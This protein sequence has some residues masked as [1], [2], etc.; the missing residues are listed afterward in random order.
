[1]Q[2]HRTRWIAGL[3]FALTLAL[4]IP[5]IAILAATHVVDYDLNPAINLTQSGARNNSGSSISYYAVGDTGFTPANL[6][7]GT[8]ATFSITL[9]SDQYAGTWSTSGGIYEVGFTY[10]P[11]T[12]TTDYLTRDG[13]AFQD[14]TN[15]LGYC[16]D[17]Y[18]YVSTSGFGAA[19][20]GYI[21]DN[22]GHTAA[23]YGSKTRFT[24]SIDA[25][26]AFQMTVEHL[27]TD[28]TTV[29]KTE[30]SSDTL[31]G[32]DAS[33][34]LYPY[35]KGRIGSDTLDAWS[36]A[37]SGA[38]LQF[39]QIEEI[40]ETPEATPESTPETT[41]ST[42]EVTPSTPEATPSTP[43]STPTTPE[44]TPSTPVPTVE[45]A[46]PVPPP[47]LRC[48]EHNAD[49]S[50][51]VHAGGASADVS[52]EVFCRVITANGQYQS[53]NGAALT[54]AG[55]IGDQGVIDMGIVQAVDVFSPS[56]S[57]FDNGIVICLKGESDTLL[58][59][60]GSQSPRTAQVIGAYSV[61]DFPGYTCATLFEPGI[62]VLTGSATGTTNSTTENYN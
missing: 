10:S 8:S 7:T 6:D 34:P 49:D 19:Q 29:L 37:Y 39:S 35:V 58:Y 17:D 46:G 59:L 12:Y 2:N 22:V 14:N 26:G 18:E 51:I 42:P 62:L 25:T 32:F 36:F 28:G 43:E 52:N 1:M 16:W 50:S 23:E 11:S 47:A 45:A 56:R 4:V 44:A 27:D 9:N 24:V 38:R 48:V 57:Y 60:A 30:T 40:I 33:R 5:T 61:P 41:P 21:Y 53:F 15:G 31:R 13:I 54:H 20:C 55:S 3:C